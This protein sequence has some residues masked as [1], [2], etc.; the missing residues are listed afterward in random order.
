VQSVW[1]IVIALTG[2]YEQILNYVIAMDF[3]FFGLTATTIFVFRR[4]AGLGEMNASDGYRMPGHPVSTAMFVAICWWVVANTIYRYPRNSLIGFVLLLAGIP[5]YWFWSRR[6]R[7]RSV[8][9]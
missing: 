7:S 1:T 5:V 3:L 6:A 4:R 9:S 8:N 2:R